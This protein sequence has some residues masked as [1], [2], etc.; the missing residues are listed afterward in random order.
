M[1]KIIHRL[2]QEPE[3]VRQHIVH[4]VVFA[5]AIIL[6]L[7]WAVSL[8]HTLSST[9]TKTTMKKDAQ[10]FTVLK[11]NIVDGYQSVGVSGN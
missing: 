5:C 1:K 11:D 2:R 9:E 4:I 7:L 10:P 3:E 6:L 8:G